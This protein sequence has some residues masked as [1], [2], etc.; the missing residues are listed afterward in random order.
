MPRFGRIPDEARRDQVAKLRAAGLTYAEIGKRLSMSRQAAQ[1]LL[2]RSKKAV[3]LP[4]I[5]CRQCHKE[6]SQWKPEWRGGM[7]RPRSVYCL[8]CLAKHPE[9][10]LR[11][12]LLAFRT[13][14]G[15]SQGELAEQT[16]M[17]KDF[18][19]ACERGQTSP[20]WSELRK[21]VKFFGV[22]LL[23]L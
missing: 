10:T 13:H 22:K 4:G 19:G 2:S 23:D 21:L 16:G 17:G 15:L 18:I 3:R 14:A 5:C 8:V 9:A 7:L 20:R 12:R 6:I 1:E 11:E